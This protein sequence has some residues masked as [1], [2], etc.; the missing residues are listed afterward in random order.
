MISGLL[1]QLDLLGLSWRPVFL[2]NVPVGLAAF[3]AALLVRSPGPTCRPATDLA[4]GALPA[5][6]PAAVP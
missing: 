3:G 2:I 5:P 6:H 4:G 1:L